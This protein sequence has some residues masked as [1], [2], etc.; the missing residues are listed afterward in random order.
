MAALWVF[1]GGGLGSLLRFGCSKLFPFASGQFPWATFCS[2]LLAAFLLAGLVTYFK[3]SAKWSVIQP[4]LVVG[5]CGGLSTFSTFTY[6]NY[7]L[8][9]QGQLTLFWINLLLSFALSL[10]LF[11]L[12]VRH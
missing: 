6:E 3:D 2:N 7:Q 9:Q 1:I 10:L 5:V 4:L 12:F 11:F 8:L